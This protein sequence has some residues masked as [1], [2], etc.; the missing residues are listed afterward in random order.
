MNKDCSMTTSLPTL[1]AGKDYIEYGLPHEGRFIEVVKGLYNVEAERNVPY[2]MTFLP[3]ANPALIYEEKEAYIGSALTPEDEA[4]LSARY[5][6]VVT[7]IKTLIEQKFSF[8]RLT[9]VGGR[10][11]NGLS[12]KF[13]TPTNRM[14]T[15]EYLLG[16]SIETI[17]PDEFLADLKMIIDGIY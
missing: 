4:T 2:T 9:F 16:S 12:F 1:I 6:E 10:S 8:D 11:N 5:V 13:R 15:K 7:A 14:Y 3:G 17:I